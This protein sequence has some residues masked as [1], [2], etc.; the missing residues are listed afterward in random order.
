MKQILDFLDPIVKDDIQE[1]LDKESIMSK[2]YMVL[3]VSIIS[4]VLGMSIVLLT[5]INKKSSLIPLTY[6]TINKQELINNGNPLVTFDYPQQS[7]AVI[8]EWIFSAIMSI[9]SFNFNEIE[10]QIDNAEY[11]FTKQG[12]AQYQNALKRMNIVETI[13]KEKIQMVT[14]PSGKPYLVHTGVLNGSI[15]FW[16]F[17]VPVSIGSY[18]GEEV[19]VKKNNI[20]ILIVRVPAYENPKGLAI[21][22]F[23]ITDRK[24][25]E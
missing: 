3:A 5:L 10:D 22:E 18:S 21:A 16:R 23:I 20:N 24:L 17:V 11:Y 13:K 2:Y 12:F 4:L 25:G 19:K 1:R 6:A 7:Y 9:Y 8:G 14:V 15:R